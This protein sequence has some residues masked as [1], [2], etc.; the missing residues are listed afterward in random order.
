MKAIRVQYTVKPEYVETNKKNILAVMAELEKN[1]IKGM[2]YKAFLLDDGQ[3]FM[4]LNLSKDEET[5][6]LLN[7]V[8][9]FNTFR[10]QLK[11]SEPLSPPKS[12]NLSLIS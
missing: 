1:P 10:M 6:G 3:T 7:G 5:M 11:A 9:Q 12:E 2:L 8:E 4:H